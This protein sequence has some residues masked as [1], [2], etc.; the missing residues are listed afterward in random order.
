MYRI[1][2]ADD[3]GIM[4]ES[5][6]SIIM[7]NY[8]DA[9][10]IVTAKTGREAI[11]QAEYFHPDIVFMDIQMPGI[12]GIQA[13]QEIRKFNITALFYVISAYDKFDYAKDAIALGVER[14]LMKPVTKRTVL[15]VTEEAIGKVDDMRRKRSDQLK[16]Q[17]KLETVIPM[18]ESGF[19]SNMLLQ[20]N[21]QETDYYRDLLEITEDYAYVIV[22]QF[23]SEIRDGQ[24]ISPVGVSIKAQTFYPEFRAVLK[25]FMRCVIGSVMTNRIVAAVPFARDSLSYE[26][27]V[28]VIGQTRNIISRL[29]E[30]LDVKFRAGIGRVRR[31]EELRSSYQEALEAM[32]NGESRVVHS[33]DTVRRGM[34]E[35]DF[36]A[37]MEKKIFTLLGR[38][39]ADGMAAEAGRFF[40]WMIRRYPGSK[41]NIRL[42]VLEYVI[43]AERDAFTAGAVN[44]GF[45]SRE[46]YLTEVLALP[47]YEGLRTWF[48][49]KMTQACLS[50]RNLKEEQSGTVV[51]RAKAYIRDNYQRDISLDDVSREVNISPYYF[52]KL[53]KEESGENFIEYLTRIRIDRARE[54]LAGS[55]HSIKEI[56]GMVG[57]ADPNYFS[58]IFKKQTGMTPREYRDSLEGRS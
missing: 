44:Y 33:Y 10:E 20:N 27:R 45:E 48:L 30:Q 46:N 52:S 58:R 9:C 34:Y 28:A 36:P 42:K 54:L 22:F 49:D 17:E 25:S 1:L 39:D 29:E 32:Q 47:D 12:N 26:E 38:G 37:D 50:I 18:V 41:D 5:I 14:Y 16:V 35:G 19:I 6:R 3:E 51:S 23:G 13:M 57:Y 15:E 53:F 21:L 4:I 24:L 7:K 31:M 8:G 11:E 40:S 55:E 43:R 56:S 2:I